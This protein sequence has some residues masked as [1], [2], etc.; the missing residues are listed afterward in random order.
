MAD[1]LELELDYE[2]YEEEEAER[3]V[4]QRPENG[5]ELGESV[6]GDALNTDDRNGHAESSSSSDEEREY[7]R[8]GEEPR[9]DDGRRRGASLQ[10]DKDWVGL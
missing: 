1:E 6:E 5:G 10:G 9:D 2:D 3:I 8:R 4:D 7:Y